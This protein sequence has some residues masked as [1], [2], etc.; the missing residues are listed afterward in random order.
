MLL[1]PEETRHAQA[2]LRVKPGDN[3]LVTDGAGKVFECVAESVD[4]G[5]CEARIVD[6]KEIPR[7]SPRIDYYIGIPERDAFEKTLECLVPLGAA[8]ITPVV[9]TFCQGRWWTAGWERFAN[10]FLRLMAAGM[11]Q[12]LSAWMPELGEVTDFAH[13]LSKARGVKV[14][15][16]QNGENIGKLSRILA[17]SDSASCFIGPPGG[18]SDEERALF[19]TAAAVPLRL[20]PLRLRTEHACASAAALLANYCRCP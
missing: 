10:R 7:I 16:D 3:L 12:S 8:S 15:G 13:A 19:R 1:A 9:C 2:V 17:A 6:T 4:G 14:Y 11:K 18:F 20:G 5:R